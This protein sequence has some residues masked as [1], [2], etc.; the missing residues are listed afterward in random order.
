MDC[1]SVRCFRLFD[2]EGNKTALTLL[3]LYFNIT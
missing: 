2:G 1:S 3:T